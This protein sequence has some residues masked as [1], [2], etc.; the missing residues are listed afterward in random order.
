MPRFPLPAVG[1]VD[2]VDDADGSG[3]SNAIA[4]AMTGGDANG[5][6]AGGFQGLYRAVHAWW[7]AAAAASAALPN[8]NRSV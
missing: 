1:V 4:D 5:D 6:L 8:S 3:A 7:S 2:G